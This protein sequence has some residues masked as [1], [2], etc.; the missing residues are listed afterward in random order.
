MIT[1]SEEFLQVIA[2]ACRN[3]RR[4]STWRR[5]IDFAYRGERGVGGTGGY[6]EGGERALRPGGRLVITY[7]SLE[8]RIVKNF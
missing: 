4:R 8:D 7:H 1:R 3:R 6:V 5:C 2:P